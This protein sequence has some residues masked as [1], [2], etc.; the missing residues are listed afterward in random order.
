MSDRARFAGAC[1]LVACAIGLAAG[2]ARA[3]ED[4]P[5]DPATP[6]PTSEFQFALR[7][8]TSIN[9]NKA[10]DR[11]S[12]FGVLDFSDTSAMA[13]A[14]TPLLRGTGRVGAMMLLTFPDAYYEPG[15][16]FL[17]EAH[18]FYEDKHFHAKIGRSRIS[19]RIIPFPTLRDDDFIRWSDA[20]NPFSDGRSTADHQFGNTLA[21]SYY[22]TPRLFAEIHAENLPTFVLRPDTI[23]AYRLNSYG[24]TLGYKQVPALIPLSIVRRIGIGVNTYRLDLPAQQVSF[25][26]L[27]GAW[28][29]VVA[30]PIHMVDVRLQAIYNRGVPR[31]PVATLNDSFRTQQVS[32][33][34]SLGYSY[35]EQMLPTFRTNVIAGYKRYLAPEI[36]HVSVAYNAFYSLGINVDV[37][38][39]YQMRTRARIPEA[40]GDDFSHSIKLALVVS[41]ETGTEPIFD[42]R[43]SLLNTESGYLP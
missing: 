33:M 42:V 27:A 22:P 40:F 1:A 7:S 10:Y 12:A 15:T 2:D 36:D 4:D 5:E 25:D 3:G 6:P 29:N 35:R 19:S 30:D 16:L 28:L 38:L 21:V 24:L 13:R 17:G 32:S 23:A 41:L 43:E 34:V 37:G 20:Q 9:G 14:R 18:A 39:Q 31:L 8:V 26:V 11:Q